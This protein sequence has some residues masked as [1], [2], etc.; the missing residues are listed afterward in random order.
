MQICNWWAYSVNECDQSS[1]ELID[2]ELY[3]PQLIRSKSDVDDAIMSITN[4]DPCGDSRRP[5]VSIACSVSE[6]VTEWSTNLS[7]HL[8]DEYWSNMHINDPQR[9]RMNC[10]RTNHHI[11]HLLLA[12]WWVDR[13]HSNELVELLIV[14]AAFTWYHCFS[15]WNCVSD[16]C[17][18][19][20]Q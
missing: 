8:S 16:D 20:L 5:T 1:F 2:C 13:L 14:S 17:D 9:L 12:R 7:L 11:H 10:I 4:T 19:W 6:R 15:V 3:K 18:H